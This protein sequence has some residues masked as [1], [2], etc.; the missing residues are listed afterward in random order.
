MHENV[1]DERLLCHVLLSEIPST[2]LRET[3]E[4]LSSLIDFYSRPA[5]HLSLSS[6]PEGQPLGVKV[7]GS[8]RADPVVLADDASPW[9]RPNDDQT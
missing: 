1:L 2:G 9:T 4:T 3:A 6:G 5:L 7:V 8:R